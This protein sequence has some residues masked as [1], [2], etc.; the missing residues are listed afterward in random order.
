MPSYLDLSIWPRRS[1]FEFF[2][3]YEKPY[4]NICAKVDVSRLREYVREATDLSFFLTSLY[5]STRAANDVESFRYRLRGDGVLVHDV[6]HIGSTVLRKN[7]TFGFVYIEFAPDFGS[8]HHAAREAIEELSLSQDALNP[9]D[10]RDDL[11]HYS[12][13]PW[14][15]F[16]SVAHPRRV[17]RDDSTP[18]IVFGKYSLEGDRLVMPVS[19]E[20][21]HGLM[22]G[23]HV[24]EYFSRLET[25]LSEPEKVLGRRSRDKR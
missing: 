4:F 9:R 2:R 19:V 13:I 10:D 8:Y 5:L 12:V 15:S 23:I 20:V 17:L 18:K 22:D 24:G 14:V 21:H 7:D 1:H 11:I 16:T 3:A 25:Y 6:I